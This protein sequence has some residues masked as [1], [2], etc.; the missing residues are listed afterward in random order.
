MRQRGAG[1]GD[2]Y[3][4]WLAVVMLAALGVGLTHPRRTSPMPETAAGAP[5]AISAAFAPGEPRRARKP[6]AGL[7]ANPPSPPEADARAAPGGAALAIVIDDL[8]PSPEIAARAAAL[9]KEVTL[10]FLPLGPA[11]ADAVR[12]AQAS[13]HEILL[14]LPMEAIEEDAGPGAL[15]VTDTGEAIAAKL[16]AGFALVPGASG[17][18]NHMGSRFTG[19]ASAVS[20]LAEALRGRDLV[21]LDSRTVNSSLAARFVRAAGLPVAEREL[22]LDH[23]GATRE[24]VLSML[25]RA[26]ALAL[27]KGSIAV[28]A[29]PYAN[30]LAA[31][32]AWLAGARRA[33]LVSLSEHVRRSARAAGRTASLVRVAPSAY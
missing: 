7:A 15:L 16:R 2:P 9:P 24:E 23:A 29:H 1:H 33:G 19:D 17:L 30:T 31:I 20:R 11:V 14:H 3:F 18:N 4:V 32:E 27:E 26:Q 25:E 6:D 22:F 13:G 10:A 5:I 12:S 28:I 8:G 21:F